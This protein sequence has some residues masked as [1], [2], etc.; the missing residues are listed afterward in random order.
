MATGATVEYIITIKG[1]GVGDG[2]RLK[3]NKAVASTAQS[4]GGGNKSNANSVLSA[5]SVG[6][7]ANKIATTIINRV[8]VTTG[9]TTMQERLNF[10][11]NTAKRLGMTGVSLIT[12]AAS[13]N[14]GMVVAS[15]ASLANW[16][17]DIGL[18]QA[19]INT[20]RRVEQI[21]I[22]QANIRAGAGGDRNGKATY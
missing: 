22:K 21:G 14:W 20:E 4:D 3:S 16:G 13:G 2:G 12:G 5:V 17:I 7:V 11:Y 9:Q 18:A 6:A 10:Q 1:E 8:G 15:V 19:N